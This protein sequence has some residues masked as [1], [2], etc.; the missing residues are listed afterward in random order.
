MLN[1]DV[2]SISTLLLGGRPLRSDKT[3]VMLARFKTKV[4]LAGFNVAE[5]RETWRTPLDDFGPDVNV[6]VSANGGKAAVWGRA[7]RHVRIV[8]LPGGTHIIDVPTAT[9]VFHVGPFYD[10]SFSENGDA[11]VTGDA[12]QR[13]IFRLAATASE[14]N[15]P[16]GFDLAGTCNPQGQVGQSN[17]GSV[18][19]RKGKAVVLLPAIIAGAPVQIGQLVPSQRVSEAIC[20]T[21]S[22]SVLV[23]PDGSSDL[24]AL[25]PSFSPRDDRLESDRMRRT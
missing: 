10:V 5:R 13:R 24:T 7:A 12:L 18:R 14:P 1:R 25:F 11:I 21:S 3:E 6:S 23:A 20:G 8:N 9:E 17:V 22:V 19:S 4:V 15:R 16:P 2:A